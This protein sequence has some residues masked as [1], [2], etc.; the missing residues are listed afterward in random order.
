M[1]EPKGFSTTLPPAQK[2]FTLAEGGD[3]GLDLEFEGYVWSEA[4]SVMMWQ[5]DEV[6]FS[7]SMTPDQL[8]AL[9]GWALAQAQAIESP[10]EVED[11]FH[12]TVLRI[13]P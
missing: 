3:D 6:L 11:A 13:E 5:G 9:A 2:T 4:A 8:R 7:A 10:P 12:P 1:S